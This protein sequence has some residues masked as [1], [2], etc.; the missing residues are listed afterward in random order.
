MSEKRLPYQISK[1]MIIQQIST[2]ATTKKS[3]EQNRTE[4]LK[5]DTGTWKFHHVKVVF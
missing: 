2:T 3:M 5:I 4:G 1:Y